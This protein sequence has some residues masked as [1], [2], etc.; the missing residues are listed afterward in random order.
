MRGLERGAGAPEDGLGHY[1]HQVYRQLV[2]PF[3]SRRVPFAAGGDPLPSLLSASFLQHIF[4]PLQHLI[5]RLKPGESGDELRSTDIETA[6]RPFFS[7]LL[8]QELHLVPL[9]VDGETFYLDLLFYHVR[10]HSYFVIR[11]KGRAIPT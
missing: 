4:D 11:I 3:A 6:T 2:L 9:T 10:L 1:Q 7:K 5:L 8:A